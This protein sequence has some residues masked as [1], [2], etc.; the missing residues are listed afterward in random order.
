VRQPERERHQVVAL[1]RPVREQVGDLEH[2]ARVVPDALERQ[3]DHLRGGIDG[4][5][6]ARLAKQV[7]GPEPGA[8]R[9]LERVADLSQRPQPGACGLDLRLPLRA[10]SI[11]LIVAAALEKPVVVL[12]RAPAVVLD[13]LPEQPRILSHTHLLT[14]IP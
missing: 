2:D 14:H 8:A 9:Q 11:A 1:H 12:R 5:Q 6:A 10:A 4:G 3:L 7:S 13:L